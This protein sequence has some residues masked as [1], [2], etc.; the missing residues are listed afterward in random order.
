MQN[1]SRIIKS[2]LRYA[3]GGVVPGKGNGDKIP[4][5]LT[6]GEVV[7]P[8]AVLR[9]HPALAPALGDMREEALEGQGKNV[10]KTN[11]QALRGPVAHFADGT[12][13]ANQEAFNASRD[14]ST[15]RAASQ[16][17]TPEAGPIRQ[18]IN[19]DAA[20][21][22]GSAAATEAAAAKPAGFFARNAAA[23]S[24]ALGKT[25]SSLVAGAKIA[26]K[27]LPLASGAAELGAGIYNRDAEQAGWGAADT[28][29]GALM[30]TPAAPVAGAYLGIRGGQAIA[31]QA[32]GEEGRDAVGGTINE[33][34]QALRRGTNGKLGWGTSPDAMNTL[35]AQD[36]AA[37]ATAAAKPSTPAA[38]ASTPA[39]SAAPAAPAA[40]VGSPVIRASPA[41]GSPLYSDDGSGNPVTESSSGLSG[42]SVV[43]NQ[44]GRDINNRLAAQ[45][46]ARIAGESNRGAGSLSGG[47]GN[48]SVDKTNA[49][50]ARSSLR[51]DMMR[52]HG[53]SPAAIAA[54]VQMSQHPQDLEQAR[55]IAQ[56]QSATSLRGQQMAADASRYGQNVAAQASNYNSDNSLRGAMAPVLAAQ[57]I[58]Q[59]VTAAYGPGG[60]QGG[61]GGGGGGNNGG[62]SSTIPGAT[63]EE[64]AQ[65]ERHNT[66]ADRLERAGLT[67][68]GKEARDSATAVTTRV[69]AR[70]GEQRKTI[71][72]L[73]GYLQSNFSDPNDPA[74]PDAQ[75]AGKA[76]ARVFA[77]YGDQLKGLSPAAMQAKAQELFESQQLHDHESQVA[78]S[79]FDR[80]KD[81]LGV[82]TPP[83]PIS[84]GDR[85]L[86]GGRTE[87]GGLFSRGNSHETLTYMPDGSVVN[88]GMLTSSQRAN[89]L[90]RGQKDYK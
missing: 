66:A 67:A 10:A 90:R 30:Y 81:K 48:S 44:A 17:A 60:S 70:G 39:V 9:D 34:G 37:A 65:F 85:D 45:Y 82:Y 86:R 31:N 29:A 32:L 78:P 89:V 79:I 76:A 58:R 40:N 88:H 74:K 46:D 51:D 25:G 7:V 16:T 12:P 35:R 6:P 38:T 62:N 83:A 42:G 1:M 14:G 73:T 52:M 28:A 53:R 71:D 4:A 20:S 33:L 11:A 36:Q 56:M 64:Q 21:P 5:M 2:G 23:A 49:E 18:P 24:S 27:A 80:V 61:S 69:A 84:I 41:N 68:Q 72:D 63:P 43:G 47:F 3:N 26:G 77:Q 57:G 75:A 22:V 55:T 50:F 59:A 87:N 8:K 54:M 19:V 13:S 15:P